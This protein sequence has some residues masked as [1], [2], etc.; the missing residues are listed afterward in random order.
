[1]DNRFHEE[2]KVSSFEAIVI[3]RS[4]KVGG[5]LE[6]Q[7]LKEN[8]SV[9]ATSSKEG[10][11]STFLD[12]SKPESIDAAFEKLALKVKSAR[13][14]VFLAGAMTHVDQCEENVEICRKINTTGPIQVAEK[15][16]NFGW[17]LT[18]FSSEYVFGGAEYRGGK[19]G[20]FSELDQPDPTCEYGRAKLE[21]EKAILNQLSTALI[22][23]TTMVFSWEPKG[24]NFLM[25][26]LRH[27]K[28]ASAGE[29][30]KFKIPKDQISTPTYGPALSKAAIDLAKMREKGIYNLVG[31][32][33]L[34]RKELVETVAEF[35]GFSP[36][37]VKRSFDFVNTSDLGQ[38]AKR[39]LTAG[40]SMDKARSK[41]I[42]LPSLK[43]A[44]TLIENMKNFSMREENF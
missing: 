7:L 27:L 37:I 8:F 23:R 14:H 22:L 20:P 44:F 2:R 43:E 25:Q 21:A 19:K 4:G 13:A 6:S 11:S 12:L 16:K 36:E 28:N 31:P 41:G 38:V 9:H 24:M 34:S 15:C 26:Y 35:F 30:K 40:L 5:G 39:P 29:Q 1:V 18:Y 32:D 17:E 10:N 42:Q 3:G 33:L